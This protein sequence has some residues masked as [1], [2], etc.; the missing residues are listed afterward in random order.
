VHALAFE[1]PVFL[2]LRPVHTG[3]ESRY[4]E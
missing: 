1:S 3:P 2:H 4:G